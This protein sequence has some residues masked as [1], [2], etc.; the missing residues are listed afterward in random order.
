MSIER[1]AT[2]VAIIVAIILSIAKIIIG[3][4][5]GSV[6]VLASAL[7]SVLDMFVSIFNNIALKIS[8]S[9]PDE[10][11]NYGKS[12]IEGLAALFEGLIIIASGLF[13]IYE[14]IRKLIEKEAITHLDASIYVMIFSIVIVGGLVAFLNYIAKKTNNLVIKSDALHYKTDLITNS[15]VLISLIIIKFT[16]WYFV[17]FILSILIGIYIIKEASEIVKEGFEIL[18][19][20]AL[21]FE[22]VEKIKE[23]IKKEP[24]VLDYHCLRTRK[25]GNRNFVDVHLVLTPDMKLKFAHTIIENVEDKIRALDHDKKWII[26]IHADPYDDSHINKL[27]EE[28]GEE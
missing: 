18:L 20:V 8:E 21:D 22:T 25:A 9:K 24:L 11:F 7:D 2:F 10:K 4:L 26:N 16:G 28:C 5:S 14:A 1:K 17:D 27:L 23:I 6:A 12:K 13:I 19:D 3:I 15:V